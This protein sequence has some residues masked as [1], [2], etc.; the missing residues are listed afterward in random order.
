MLT[1]QDR[2][3][4]K[5]TETE[6]RIRRNCI[7]SWGS[8]ACMREW[9]PNPSGQPTFPIQIVIVTRNGV[10]FPAVYKDG[11][12]QQSAVIPSFGV[13]RLAP[14][15]ECD[16]IRIL[17]EPCTR[18]GA[19]ILSRL[20]EFEEAIT[21]NLDT[22]VRHSTRAIES[23]Q[24]GSLHRLLFSLAGVEFVGNDGL[25]QWASDH[26][27]RYLLQLLD[28]PGDEDSLIAL[29]EDACQHLDLS[30]SHCRALFHAHVG[31]SLRTYRR[32]QRTRRALELLSSGNP[33]SL[34]AHQVGF[35]SI[36][37]LSRVFSEFFGCSPSRFRRMFQVIN[38][39]GVY[40][41]QSGYAD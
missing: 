31:L 37:H 32:W 38:G 21:G 28:C 1:L 14:A 20:A 7:V 23:R 13:W 8:L 3:H 12:L 40:D 36:S 6:F 29:V 26:R 25:E 34:I 9:F 35:S 39:I 17:I 18:L 30:V 27:V 2:A 15:Y 10:P 19:A 16:L 5:P 24:S 22:L 4:S 41:A 33:L 11:K